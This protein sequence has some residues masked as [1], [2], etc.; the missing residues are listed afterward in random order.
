MKKRV[1]HHAQSDHLYT[2]TKKSHPQDWSWFYRGILRERLVSSLFFQARAI[3]PSNK[4]FPTLTASLAAL[5]LLE[6]SSF[7][8][9]DPSDQS[10]CLQ[11]PIKC[12]R[13][14]T[15][16]SVLRVASKLNARRLNHPLAGKGGQLTPLMYDIPAPSNPCPASARRFGS[17]IFPCGY[18]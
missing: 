14:E 18:R 17:L 7:A 8:F 4:G 10:T 16:P 1:K 12:Q 6:S 2:Q 13:N 3:L 9:R 11:R 15:D 5:L